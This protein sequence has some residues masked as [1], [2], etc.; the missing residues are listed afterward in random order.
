M[1]VCLCVFKWAL[2]SVFVY[3]CVFVFLCAC[4]FVFCVFVRKRAW[5]HVCLFNYF[6]WHAHTSTLPFTRAHTCTDARARTYIYTL[7][8]LH[9]TTNTRLMY[10]VK[11]Y[12]RIKNS[13]TNQ[14]R[15]QTERMKI[16]SSPTPSKKKKG[17]CWLIHNF[18]LSVLSKADATMWEHKMWKWCHRNT[19]NERSQ[20]A[21]CMQTWSMHEM[22]HFSPAR[23]AF[24]ASKKQ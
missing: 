16:S 1:C 12:V 19:T 11:F 4:V 8:Q 14:N 15:V 3:V 13:Q 23:D 5:E 2:G 18:S 21:I 7:R 9:L 17:I 22:M 6:A 24:S 10:H 20:A